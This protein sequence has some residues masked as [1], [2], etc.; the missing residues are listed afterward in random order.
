MMPKDIRRSLDVFVLVAFIVFLLAIAIAQAVM[1]RT[2]ILEA[3]MILAG[4]AVTVKAWFEL[5]TIG[6][7]H[8]Q[9]LAREGKT[10]RRR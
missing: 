1:N 9:R 8:Q 4:I 7:K 2:L 5:E 3:L 10:R 6:R